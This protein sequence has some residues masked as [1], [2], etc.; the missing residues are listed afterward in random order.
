M[1]WD[2]D[3]DLYLD[4]TRTKVVEDGCDEAAF[5]LCRAGQTVAAELVDQYKLEDKKARRKTAD[6]A[7]EKTADKSS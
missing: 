6:K 4:A 2:A 1:R 5:L 7:V 3:R